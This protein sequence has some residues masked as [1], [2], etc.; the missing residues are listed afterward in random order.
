MPAAHDDTYPKLTPAAKDAVFADSTQP[1]VETD[2]GKVHGYIRNG[3]FAFKGIPYG[4]DAGGAAR[5]MPP[6]K[7][8]PLTTE[9]SSM[10]Y[11]SVCPQPERHGWKNDEEAWM[12]SWDDP[13]TA[14]IA[15]KGVVCLSR[16]IIGSMSSAILTSPRT[17]PGT[18]SRLT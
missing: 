17:D 15:R 6:R 12:F 8:K 4:D 13:T 18:R 10:Q 1:V 3:I 9:R 5:F 7:A 11:G 16:L 14:T 2:L